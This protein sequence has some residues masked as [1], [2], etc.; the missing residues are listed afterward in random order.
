MKRLL[1]IA[2]AALLALGTLSIAPAA[3]PVETMA[4]AQQD[5]L[6]VITVAD[7]VRV[8]QGRAGSTPRGYD[9]LQ[10]Y[11]TSSA[12]R[13]T[14]KAIAGEYHLTQLA[15][16][17]IP[18]LKVHCAVFEIPEDSTQAMM[19]QMLR[20]EPR[21]RLAEP[22][23]V[24]ETRS[25]TYNDPYVGL[26]SGF[27]QLDVADAHGLSRGD[28]VRVAVIDTGVDVDHP[29]LRKKIV[30]TRDL[31]GG[32]VD[33][34]RSDRHGTEVTGVIAA[35]ANNHVGIVGVAPGVKLIALKACW[36]L[37]EGTDNARCNSFTLAKAISAA[38]DLKSQVVNLS[39]G[40]PSDRLLSE[41]VETG[42]QRG[43]V[44]VGAASGAGSGFPQ[45]VPGVLAVSASESGVSTQPR[46]L[47]AP[48]REIL[49]LLPKDHYDFASGSSLAVAH[50][51]GTVALMLAH[52][53]GLDSA[54]IFDLLDRTSS[55]LLATGS[56]GSRSINACAALASIDASDSSRTAMSD[57]CHSRSPAQT[58]H[59]TS[60]PPR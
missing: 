15:E 55:P 30:A 53:P 36:Q 8:L 40:G 32:T 6:I 45:D 13:A 50:V 57:M 10:R 26:Q 60:Q 21:V 44:F 20:A 7:D 22:M 29:D 52:H 17:P 38:I 34:F 9:G 19:L 28:G 5:R 37:E 46:L 49:T 24:F 42:I 18:L 4:S 48:G 56:S 54:R 33:Q 31:V 16:W 43:I 27:R 59:A 14:M 47:H 35:L 1:R 39:L 51:T 12:A 2:S 11:E 58:A 3:T 25:E 41:L 23:G